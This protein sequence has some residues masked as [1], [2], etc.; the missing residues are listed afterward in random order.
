MVSGPGRALLAGWV[1]GVSACAAPASKGER[2]E[3]AGAAPRVED[4]GSARRADAVVD[5]APRPGGAEGDYLVDEAAAR[6]GGAVRVIVRWPDT[7]RARRTSP[8]PSGCGG[9]RLPT[10]RPDALWGVGDVL[11]ALEVPRGLPARPSEVALTV[12]DCAVRPRLAVAHPGATLGIE[13]RDGALR[14]VRVRGHRWRSARQFGPSPAGPARGLR[15]PWRG[16]RVE[17]PLPEPALWQIEGEGKHAA[18]DAAWLVV[19]PHPYVAVTNGAG[20][21]VFPD[22]PA[23]DVVV[24]GWLPARGGGRALTLRGETRVHTGETA[25]VVLTP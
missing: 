5:A 17:L 25:E 14:A 24:T 20:A 2:R 4:A 12:E 10:A 19:A 13:S 22:V 23:G 11:V 1:C 16:H 15:L 3:D 9:E 21:A 6:A 7:P 8:G 18:E